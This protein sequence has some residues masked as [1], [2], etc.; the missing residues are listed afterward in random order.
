MLGSL[1]EVPQANQFPKIPFIPRSATS[2]FLPAQREGVAFHRCMALLI[3]G[4]R[5]I[6]GLNEAPGGEMGVFV[7]SRG[8][9]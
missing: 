7:S 3:R 1:A 4:I 6:C 8:G 2:R 9:T 5:V